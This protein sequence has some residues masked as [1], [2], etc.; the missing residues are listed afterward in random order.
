M[1][2]NEKIQKGS[3]VIDCVKKYVFRINGLILMSYDYRG[4]NYSHPQITI[5]NQ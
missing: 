4:K 2:K 5:K 1:V 3:S